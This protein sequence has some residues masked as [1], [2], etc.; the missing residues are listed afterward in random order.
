MVFYR[1]E[2]VQARFEQGLDKVCSTVVQW[3]FNGWR[4]FRSINHRRGIRTNKGVFLKTL[5]DSYALNVGNYPFP[6]LMSR[7]PA[8]AS[9][10]AT[11]YSGRKGS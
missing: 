7:M 4:T 10:T 8:V 2:K 6:L 1:I 11:M 5:F 9:A 3:L